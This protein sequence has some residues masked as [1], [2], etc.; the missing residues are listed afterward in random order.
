VRFAAKESSG[1]VHTLVAERVVILG[2]NE[3]RSEGKWLYR[4]ELGRVVTRNLQA[5]TYDIS[6]GPRLTSTDKKRPA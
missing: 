1:K 3:Y 4:T 2:E 6:D 5:G